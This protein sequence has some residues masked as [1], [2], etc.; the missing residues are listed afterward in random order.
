MKQHLVRNGLVL[1]AILAVAFLFAAYIR[2]QPGAVSPKSY[3]YFENDVVAGNVS[4]IVR[5][6][7]TLTITEIGGGQYTVLSD[8]PQAGEWAAIRSWAPPNLKTLTYTVS[9]PASNSW[10]LWLATTVLPLGLGIGLIYFFVRRGQRA[11]NL[12]LN[13]GQSRSRR[14]VGDK[15]DVTF[16]DVAGVDEAKAE[17]E[18]VVEFLKY[19]ERFN[20]LGA[21]IPRGVLLVGPP[22]S[23]KTLISKAVAGQ[24][25]VPFFSISG[26]EFVEM[27]TGMGAKR[28]RDLFDQAKHNA[29]S[30]L[31]IDEIDAVGR[32]RGTSASDT[33]DEREQ[34]LNQILVEMD[35]FGTDTEVI[36]LAATNRPDVLDPALLRPGRFDRQVILDRPDLRGRAAILRAHSKDK[37]LSATVDLEALART[38]AGMSGA[39]LAN[40]VNE[41]AI[42]AG[43]RGRKAIGM[44]EFKEALERIVSGPERRSRIISNAEKRIIAIHE[45]GHT[46][47]GRILPKCDPVRRVAI[48]SHGLALGSTMTFSSEDRYL[49]SKS[50]FKD[51]LASLLAGNAA[52]SLIF[53]D[54]TTGSA[55]DIEKAT[56]LARRMVTEWGMSEQMGPLSFGK[57]DETLFLGRGFAEPRSYSDK[58]AELIDSEVR[59]FVEE[60]LA[61]AT[62]VLI[63]HKERLLTLAELLISQE[64][65]EGEDLEKLFAD[66]PP[67][68][69]L[70]GLP[71]L[72]LPAEI[73]AIEAASAFVE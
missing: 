8:S 68:E 19:P 13:L 23:G 38:S 25:G 24:A 66:L 6:D 47:V 52:E 12:I 46:L 73:E 57:R 69:D 71:P 45:G 4:T 39:D 9:P 36:V 27:F 53:G 29:P 2:A 59:T 33:H 54:T 7:A 21:R 41:A 51:K 11:D 55:D 70:H 34:T 14:F 5:S 28:V 63:E 30:I 31:F 67:K 1:I 40:L 72:V 3:S 32:L 60:G 26:S 62:A 56:N 17:L 22:G 16:D 18:Q 44:I 61:R 48:I 65:M 43:R 49:A 42:I 10:F 15:T 20:S 64:T 35:G 58:V 37:P 50:E